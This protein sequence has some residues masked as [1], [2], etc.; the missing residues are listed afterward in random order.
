M[1]IFVVIVWFWVI[2]SSLNQQGSS[3]WDSY[4]LLKN[5]WGVQNRFF[6]NENMQANLIAV[7]LAGDTVMSCMLILI[8]QPQCDVLYSNWRICSVQKYKL[9]TMPHENKSKTIIFCLIW[10]YF[11]SSFNY[12]KFSLMSRFC[13]PKKQFEKANKTLGTYLD[14]PT[15][16]LA[17]ILKRFS[18]VWRLT[19]GVQL[20]L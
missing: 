17:L 1:C 18:L 5:I 8:R 4:I 2:K 16:L 19:E 10:L 12:E 13:V 15:S 9:N 7:I 3:F 20:C 14:S 6:F 11:C